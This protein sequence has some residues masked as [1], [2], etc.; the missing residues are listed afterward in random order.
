MKLGIRAILL[1]IC[2]LVSIGS[3]AFIYE[4]KVLKKWDS[5]KNRY[6]YFIG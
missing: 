1:G 5:E 2:G 3:N 4:V 6:Q